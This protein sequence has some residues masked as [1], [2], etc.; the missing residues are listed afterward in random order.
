MDNAV[1][2]THRNLYY[3]PL[4]KDS[5]KR[6]D[7]FKNGENKEQ[8]KNSEGTISSK[9]TKGTSSNQETS[10][11]LYYLYKLQTEKKPELSKI[12][13]LPSK[14][15]SLCIWK[16]GLE[17]ITRS[18]LERKYLVTREAYNTK[19]INDILC[20]ENSHITATFKDYLMVDDLNEFLKRYYG[21]IESGVR[22]PKI[23]NFF[24]KYSKL[25]PNYMNLDERK[26]MFKN[27][28]KKQRVIDK[29]HD[30]VNEQN[31]SASS[32]IKD[33]RN[34]IFTT[35]FLN[36]LNRSDS[37]LDKSSFQ[38]D[39]M[40]LNYKNNKLHLNPDKGILKNLRNITLKELLDKVIMK[41][42][43]SITESDKN[44]T[45]QRQEDRMSMRKVI[46]IPLINKGKRQ[47]ILKKQFFTKRISKSKNTSSF[48]KPIIKYPEN[49][50]HKPLLDTHLFKINIIQKKAIKVKKRVLVRHGSV[51]KNE[52]KLV[53]HKKRLSQDIKCSNQLE[54]MSKRVHKKLLSIDI[55]ALNKKLQEQKTTAKFKTAKST[56]NNL[57]P[58][59]F[60]RISYKITQRV[61]ERENPKEEKDKIRVVM[62]NIVTPSD[63]IIKKGRNS[64]VLE[65]NFINTRSKDI[66][67][68]MNKKG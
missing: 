33:S 50:R 66:K 63:N 41:D 4:H 36:E 27:I 10:E 5:L 18:N 3:L 16:K 26:F 38:S 53:I 55:E 32:L 22:V 44:V 46:N 25:F 54:V 61:R 12:L 1:S 24:N 58:D 56:P 39:S 15:C 60:R 23:C 64:A 47:I 28:R 68:L 17:G 6:K 51:A 43:Q 35:R 14:D 65:M 49:R 2:A 57:T 31:E 9:K 34:T 62:K 21:R 40:I 42:T 52:M 8:L 20:N 59:P 37:I 19:I 30:Q 7:D 11:A 45:T 48:N 13:N 29:V 67:T